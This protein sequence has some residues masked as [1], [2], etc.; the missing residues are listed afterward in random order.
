MKTEMYCLCCLKNIREAGNIN[1][2]FA[3][4]D[5]LCSKCRYAL[6]YYPQNIF[7]SDLKIYGLYRYEGLVRELLIQYK[8]YNDEALYPI[9]LYSH[10]EYL[11]IKYRDYYLVE[12]PSNEKSLKR[13]GFKHVK[14]LYSLLDLPFIDALYN[15]STY[16]QKELSYEER[17][18]ISTHIHVKI[19]LK[20]LNDKKI[21]LVDDIIT[22]GSTLNAAYNALKGN[23]KHIEGLVIAYNERYL[24]E[25]KKMIYK[26]LY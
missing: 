1:E 18:K 14:K 22:G 15:D 19:D 11:K 9:F 3:V 2:I 10:I 12:I 24:S 21:L 7:I 4:N 20:E 5:L 6:K 16:Q 25:W 8:E 13:R 23:C 17:K 26:L